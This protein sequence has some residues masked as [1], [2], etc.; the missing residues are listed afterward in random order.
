LVIKLGA[1]LKKIF[2]LGFEGPGLKIHVLKERSCPAPVLEGEPYLQ[3]TY[4]IFGVPL[5]G[6]F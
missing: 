5:Y 6:N 2:V 3:A 4:S 1:V